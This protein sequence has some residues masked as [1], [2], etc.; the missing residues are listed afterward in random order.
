[1]ITSA[2]IHAKLKERPFVPFRVI[3]SSGAA[4][5][6]KHP[7]LAVVGKRHLFVGTASEDNPTLFDKSSLLSILH[8]AAIEALP[9]ETATMQNGQQ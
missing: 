3:L 9:I 5:D 2:D 8:V 7:D 4:Y 6:I 1:M